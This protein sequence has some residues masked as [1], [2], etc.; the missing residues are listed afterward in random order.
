VVVL[1]LLELGA[2]ALGPYLTEPQLWGDDATTVKVAQMDARAATGACTDVVVAGNSMG[3]D[4][5]VPAAFTATDP[6]HR[7]AYNASLD[8]ASPELLERWVTDE[9]V[10][11]LHPKTVVLTLASL[12]LNANSLAGQAAVQAYDDATMSRPGVWGRIEADAA[13][14]SALVRYRAQLRQPAEVWSALGRLRDGTAAPRLSADGI[15]GVL[16]PDGEGVSRR[17]LHYN[18]SPV[19]KAFLTG[20]LLNDYVVG[21]DQVAAEG[22][23][24]DDLHDQGID[25]VLALPPVSDDYRALHPGGPAAVD[26]FVTTAHQ[27]AD[28]HHAQ[29]VDL[30]STATPD[31]FADTHHLNGAGADAFTRALPERLAAAGVPVNPCP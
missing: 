7:P 17:D 21:D 18:G 22:R 29:F 14:D 8:A 19:T 24:I 20:E 31:Q 16:G 28:Q 3:R 23:L 15:P 26:R 6:A 4:A 30:T 27:L 25:V 2:R 10:P 11:R 5:F 13:Q 9:V 1:V 12:D